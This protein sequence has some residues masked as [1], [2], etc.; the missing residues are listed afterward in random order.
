VA[1]WLLKSEPEVWSWQ[2]MLAAGRTH[3]DGI[4]NHQANSA[5]KAMRTGDRAFFYHSGAAR[6]IVGIVEVVREAYPDPSDP[7]GRFAM[8][9]VQATASLPV[10]VGLEP[11]K[12]DARLTHLA[13]VRQGRLSVMPVDDDAWRILCAMGGAIL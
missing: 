5:L 1:Y 10:P 13:L 2:Q 6:A 4:R 3:W 12:A 11:I 7:S 8:V 9:D